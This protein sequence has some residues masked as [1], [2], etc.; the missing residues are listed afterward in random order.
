MSLLA[1]FRLFRPSRLRVALLTGA[2]A[3]ALATPAARAETALAI[4]PKLPPSETVALGIPKG[5][6]E[7]AIA[8]LDDFAAA[9]MKRSGIPGMAVVVVRDGKTVYLKGFGVREVGKPETVDGDTVFQLASLSKAVGAGVVAHQVG[10]G[11]VT[12]D[13]PLRKL[14]PWF[15]LKDPWVGE[16]VTVADLYTHR[17]GL[18]DHAG[19]ELEDL[20][21][22]R[23]QILERLKLLP[24][25]PFRVT[26]AYTNFGLT[27]AAEGVAAASGKDWATL[28]DEVLY[29]PLGMSATSSRFSDYIARANRAVP[30][31]RDNGAFV[32]KYQRQ[33][34]AQSPAGGVSSSARDMGRWLAFVLGNGAYEGQQVVPA[35]ALL[36]A[37][38][39]QMVSTPSPTSS[40]RAGFYGH[41]FNVSVAPSGRVELSHSGAFIL[42]AG[43]TFA[44][45]PSEK[46]GIAVLTNAQPVGAA[47]ALS[48]Q[49]MDYVQF[50][51]IT[52]D[53]FA[54]YT[55]LMAPLYQPL[56]ALT[57]LPAPA[58]PEP[59]G[60]L[61]DYAGSYAS[62]YFGPATVRVEDGHLVL[63]MG[64]K[65]VV[66]TLGHWSGD[67]FTYAPTGESA[68]PGT[69]SEVTF[70]LKGK[71][72]SA[73]TVE[74]FN[75]NGLGTFT[76]QPAA[77]PEK[78]PKAKRHN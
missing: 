21:F 9:L 72:A 66:A 41:G 63:T 10:A 18:P 19:D 3:A 74:F 5:Q 71:T 55:A 13:T 78:S 12:W 6:V 30:H 47:E 34:D 23:R 40:A 62:P 73:M 75:E 38:T 53:W 52:R 76:R 48:M 65:P 42:G 57:G 31:V 58:T 25:A 36:P 32:A 35:A 70:T 17:S 69:L 20:G 49:F 4:D 15:S 43:T 24:L 27:A 45:L 37:I 59:A 16:H 67:V 29:K 39:A 26:Y 44:M 56:G 64:P 50:G 22:D 33:P 61:E 14:L 60:K 68:P 46:I 1:L 8:K 54:A 51:S 28:S 7:A 11:V 2:C 77:R